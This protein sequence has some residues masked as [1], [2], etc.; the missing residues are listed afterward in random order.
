MR[1]KWKCHKYWTKKPFYERK[2]WKIKNFLKTPV[3]EFS[4]TEDLASF[5]MYR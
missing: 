2:A 4:K 3:S 1:Q 5:F